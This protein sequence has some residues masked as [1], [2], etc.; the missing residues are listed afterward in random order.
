VTYAPVAVI[1]NVPPA[2]DVFET[3]VNATELAP[4]GIVTVEGSVVNVTP[5]VA[6]AK[7]TGSADVCTTGL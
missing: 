1:V 6:Y 5:V 7:A 2:D 4:T 3:I